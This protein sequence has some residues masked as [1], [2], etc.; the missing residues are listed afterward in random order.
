MN[1]LCDLSQ[2]KHWFRIPSHQLVLSATSGACFMYISVKSLTSCYYNNN[3]YLRSCG[4]ARRKKWSQQWF[5]ICTPANAA[6]EFVEVDFGVS[7]AIVLEV[8]HFRS[9]SLNLCRP[10]QYN[11]DLHPKMKLSWTWFIRPLIVKNEV[12]TAGV[13]AVS[14][15]CKR[16]TRILNFV[17][18]P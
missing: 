12:E 1:W 18:S 5:E 17:S 6:E 15:Y 3:T 9:P 10:F 2:E 7:P 8:G 13:C 11:T 16:E 14:V 4:K